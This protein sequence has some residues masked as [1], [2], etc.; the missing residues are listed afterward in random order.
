MSRGKSKETNSR[1]LVST[2]HKFLEK[3]KKIKTSRRP[4]MVEGEKHEFLTKEHKV[5]SK[6]VTDLMEKRKGWQ[7][8][9]L[10]KGEDDSKPWSEEM[11]VKVRICHL[12]CKP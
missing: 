4:K 5:S 10:I 1:M 11:R 12:G 2:L 8:R 7:L 9:K 3:A 6:V